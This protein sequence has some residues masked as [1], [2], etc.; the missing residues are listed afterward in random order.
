MPLTLRGVQ[1]PRVFQMSGATGFFGEGY[2][3]HHYAKMVGM[4]WADTVF[5]AKT[6]TLEGRGGNMP[7][8]EDGI[9]PKEW[10]P[11]CIVVKPFKGVTLN[12]VGLSGPGLVA[13]LDKG[14]WQKRKDPF[15]I[16]FMS[17]AK[18]GAERAQELSAAV[19]ILKERKKEFSAPWGFQQNFSCPNVG[20]DTHELLQEV[21]IALNI[22]EELAVPLMPKFDLR[23]LPQVARDIT[24]HPTCD[25]IHVSNALPWGSLPDE[26]NWKKLFG[27]GTSPLAEY[28]GGGLSG[29]PLLPLLIKWL[30]QTRRSRMISKPIVAG[31]GVLSAHDAEAVVKLGADAIALGTIG[32]LRPWR[33]KETIRRSYKLY[34]EELP[35]EYE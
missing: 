32:I 16:S 3:F 20:L 28:G 1:F 33:M 19:R 25:A 5:V 31:G 22:T 13:L 21:R 9:T 12:A 17:V 10:K 30:A 14:Q 23:I 11:K 6:T 27:S 26:I 29:K 8:Q 18:T 2:P 34:G 35:C 24:Q 4:N 15:W 7:M